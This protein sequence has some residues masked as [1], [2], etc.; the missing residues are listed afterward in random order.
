MRTLSNTPGDSVRSPF[1]VQDSAPFL[2]STK[3]Q[4]G[5]KEFSP[6]PAAAPPIDPDTLPVHE[7]AVIEAALAILRARMRKPGNRVDT[8]DAAR[9]MAMLYFA[10]HQ[11]E[12]FAVM[13]LDPAHRLIAFEEMSRGTLT[14]TNVYPREIVRAALRHNAASVIL[15]HNHPSGYAEPSA[16]DKLL[17]AALKDALRTVDVRTLDHFVIGGDQLFSFAEQGIL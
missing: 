8:P 4:I 1:P 10:G 7:Q 15:T 12:S 14:Q 5:A 17:T 6:A 3:Q 11:V 16:A 2:E 13:F 9:S